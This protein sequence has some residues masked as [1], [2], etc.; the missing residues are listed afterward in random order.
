GLDITAELIPLAGRV[1]HSFSANSA[2]ARA[3]SSSAASSSRTQPSTPPPNSNPETLPDPLPTSSSR[4]ATPKPRTTWFHDDGTVQFEDG[5]EERD[6]DYCILATGYEVDFPFFTASNAPA[7]EPESVDNDDLDEEGREGQEDPNFELSIDLVPYLPPHI[8][9]LPETELI[10]T[11]FGVFPLARH[12]FGIPGG[13]FAKE[14]QVEDPSSPSPSASQPPSAAPQRPS[15]SVSA[16]SS[17]VASTSSPPPSL[18]PP[19]SLAFLGLLVRVAPL[20][21]VEVQ[22]RAA[23]AAFAVGS[24]PSSSSSSSSPSSSPESSAVESA[25]DWHLEETKILKRWQ[26]LRAKFEAELDL[27][28]FISK[29]WHKLSEEGEQFD[30]RDELDEFAFSLLSSSS[31]SSSNPT[32]ASPSLP[33]PTPTPTPPSSHTRTTPA[34][35][36]PIPIRRTRVKPWERHFY[37]HKNTLRKA[38]RELEARGWAEEWVRG[39][40]SGELD[41]PRSFE[42]EVGMEL[43]D[44]LERLLLD[45]EGGVGGGGRKKRTREERAEAEWVWFMG[46]VLEFGRGL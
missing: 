14:P 21:L 19:T 37:T 1:L 22:A 20:P 45:D 25:I 43:P 31:P 28:T 11:T 6:V 3:S 41:I 24:S 2:A 4:G 46:K 32:P 38:W 26:D 5:S 17:S 12:L 15:G 35:A 29:E 8:S 23:L 13:N 42:V 40:G 10:N 36:H 33:T 18:P 16:S 30:Y 9:H 34:Q 27:R 44:A 39:V 7:P